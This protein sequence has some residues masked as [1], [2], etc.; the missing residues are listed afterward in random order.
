MKLKRGMLWVAVFV[1]TAL[2][3]SAQQPIKPNDLGVSDSVITVGTLVPAKGVLA[4][5]GTVVKALLVAYCD[6]LNSKGGINGRKLEVKFVETGETSAGTKANL[7]RLVRDEHV[8]ALLAPITAG[9][10]KEVYALSKEQGLPIVG[11][12]TLYPDI[13]PPINRYSFYVLSGLDTQVR[14]FVA[15][16]MSNAAMKSKNFGVISTGGERDVSVVNS[17]KDQ[18]KKSGSASDP[19]IY[20]IT[21]GRTDAPEFV[22]Q[23]RAASPGVILF[24][25]SPDDANLFLK[26]SARTIWYPDVYLGGGG[27][28]GIFDLPIGFDG[29]IFIAV[30]VSPSD[31]TDFG[32]SLFRSLTSKYN[33]PPQHRASQVIALAAAQ[34]FAEG[35]A[36]AGKNLTRETLI[37]SLE[38]LSN[39]TTGLTQ[40][41]SYSPTR[42]IGAQGAYVIKVDLKTK[43]LEP[44]SD[45][46]PI[47]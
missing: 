3:V 37:T 15:F 36:R 25:G 1:A 27:G 21:S 17:I 16:A 19:S 35:L 10:E 24:L 31:Q 11:P 30:S 32:V 40:P 12:L 4:P 41:I 47:N 7:E 33:I 44:A 45:W 38:S 14:A 6:E 42:H 22:K 46:L 34:I 43:S 13:G 2:T 9:A 18:L 5:M 39:F 29:K 28:S 23:V 26:E 8:F 20:P